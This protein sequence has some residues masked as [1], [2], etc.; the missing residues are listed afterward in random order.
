MLAV[1]WTCGGIGVTGDEA[2]PFS[3]LFSFIKVLDQH[4]PAHPLPFYPSAVVVLL[5]A[6]AAA[7]ALQIH[8]RL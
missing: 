8:V 4:S 6:V 7:G 2:F 1:R 3:L 5:V